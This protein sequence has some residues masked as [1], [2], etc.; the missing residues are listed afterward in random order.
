M[1]KDGNERAEA[2]ALIQASQHILLH[3]HPK[4]DLDSIGSALATYHALRGLGKNVTVMEGDSKLP[5]GFSSL[6][7]YEAI[8][9][10]NYFEIDLGEYDLFIIQ[11]SGSK[12]LVSRKGEVIFPD[13]LKTLV[14][15]HHVTNNRYAGLNLVDASYAATSEFLYDLFEAWGIPLTAEIAACLFAG[16]YGD[17]GGFKYS[18][19]TSRTLKIGS[20]LADHYPEFARMI[21]AIENSNSKGKL[22]FDALALNAIESFLND[23][24]AISA[25]SYEEMQKRNITREDSDNSTVANMLLTVKQW[26]VAVTLIEKL[27]GEVQISI[28]SKEKDISRVAERLGG[29]GHLLAGGALLLMSLDEAKKKVKSALEEM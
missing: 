26:K 27:P 7:G 22:Y 2:F 29:G 21:S 1:I 13:T 12:Q 16:I 10:K 25:V 4:P 6:P 9:H 23:T 28:R 15:D 24:V 3:L 5:E 14:I 19:T 20:V 11:D 17:T 18:S 8:V